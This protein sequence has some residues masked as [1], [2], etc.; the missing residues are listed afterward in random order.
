[1]LDALLHFPRRTIAFFARLRQARIDHAHR[2]IGHALSR[3]EA[4]STFSNLALYQTELCDGF[5]EGFSLFRVSDHVGNRKPGTADAGYAKFQ[6]PHIEN[7]EC[8]VMSFTGFAQKVR[9]RNLAI[10]KDK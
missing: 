2:A 9:R 7:D 1:L 4:R 3:V 8:D 10:L 5:P 6:A